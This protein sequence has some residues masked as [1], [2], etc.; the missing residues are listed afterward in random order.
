MHHQQR[1][2][3]MCLAVAEGASTVLEVA[4]KVFSFARFTSHEVRFALAETFAHLEHLVEEG[5]LERQEVDGVWRYH[6]CRLS[7]APPSTD[8]LT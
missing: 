4:Q 2:K 5:L 1:L 7:Q 6:S 8:G 3:E